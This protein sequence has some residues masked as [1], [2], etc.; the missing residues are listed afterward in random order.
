MSN[1][2][3]QQV[4]DEHLA[5]VLR[6]DPRLVAVSRIAGPLEPRIH[7]PGFEGLARVVCGQQ[8]SVAS[9]R[10]IWTRFQ[11]RGD[12]SRDP[13]AY[14]ETW[15]T[16]LEGVGLSRSKLMTLQGV[17]QAI[18]DGELDLQHV[19]TLPIEQAM[20]TLTQ[21]KG[22]GPWTAEI[23]L[24]F[25]AGHPDV[26]PVGDLALRKAVAH[27]FALK[28]SSP[29]ALKPIVEQWAPWRTVCALMFWRYYGVVDR[30]DVLP[31]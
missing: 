27:A 19:N 26:F 21:Y 9:A 30:K 11:E 20:S 4:V 6:Q 8:L 31:V 25:C 17:A 15:D 18:V 23:Y 24:M 16:A 2:H 1:I 7:P 5:Q 3:D 14:L 12:T 28:D 22:I 10:A 13:Q 29:A